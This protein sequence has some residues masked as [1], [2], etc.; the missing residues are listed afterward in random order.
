MEN[1]R[2]ITEDNLQVCKDQIEHL[3]IHRSLNI[4]WTLKS[5]ELIDE[6]MGEEIHRASE[7]FTDALKE[8]FTE[9]QVYLIYR[10]VLYTRKCFGKTE[11]EYYSRSI[12][13]RLRAIQRLNRF[14]RLIDIMLDDV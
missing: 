1:H 5:Q 8:F 11:T 4:D 14:S 7:Q 10:K 13:P 6:V 9:K 2:E 3:E 12:K